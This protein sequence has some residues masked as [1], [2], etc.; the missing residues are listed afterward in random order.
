MRKR[1]EQGSDLGSDSEWVPGHESDD[2][3]DEVTAAVASMTVPSRLGADHAGPVVPTTGPP[4]ASTISASGSSNQLRHIASNASSFDP[5]PA[6]SSQHP[7]RAGTANS[8][9]ASSSRLV[10]DRHGWG[11]DRMHQQRR[12]ELQEDEDD[13]E[14]DDGE[15]EEDDEEEDDEAPAPDL[16]L[17]RQ[18][19]KFERLSA[20]SW[21]TVVSEYEDD[22]KN[23]AENG[24][25]INQVEEEPKKSGVDD[26][27][28]QLRGIPALQGRSV[29]DCVVELLKGTRAQKKKSFG[30]YGERWVWLGEDLLS[31]CYKSK[32]KE[33]HGRLNLTKVKKL[34]SS[35][36]ELVIEAADDRK[37]SL[38]LGTKD[39]AMIWLT[40]LSCLVPK[41]AKVTQSNP[42]LKERVNYDP[43]KDMWRG[44][45]LSTRKRV[46]EYI[47]L[48]GIGRGSFGKVKLALST[49]DKRF[50]AVKIITK[51][52]KGS[53]QGLIGSK[54]EQAMLRKL[55]HPNICRHRD[56]LYDDESD[57]FIIVVEYMARGVVM[58]SSKLEGVKPLSE[59]GV[60]EIMRDVVCGLEYLHFQNIVHRDLKPD[61]LLRAGDGTV[62]LSD[63]GE[64]RMYDLLTPEQRVKPSAP[65]TPAFIAPE[66]CMSD[67]GPK[68]PLESYAADIWSLGATMFYMVYGR[69]PFL[70]KSVFEIYDAICSQKLEFPD[71]PKISKKLRDLLKR[72]LT[73]EPS[74]RVTL[75]DVARHPW[76]VERVLQPRA[77]SKVNISSAEIKDAIRPATWT[78]PEERGER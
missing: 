61:N 13:D 23:H 42:I 76:F 49:S 66:L 33:E 15:E 38:T 26:A 14:P 73:K 5:D 24:W 6:F 65:G 32:R 57:R 67:K 45:L 19:A 63:F 52:K 8:D 3:L 72:M 18:D 78:I 27:S 10:S 37:L 53:T 69:A 20:D 29:L 74:R 55:I 48:G 44:K 71:Q 9:L 58:D 62:K 68:A 25:I 41:K 31:L 12:T 35:D 36:R 60:R 22:N 54:E 50:Y 39:E 21:V 46:N 75:E 4:G 1:T 2:G 70:A 34:K 11:A 47:L 40:G 64:A 77:L 56:I 30:R 16:S 43:L 7:S 17:L 28:I 51:G 59:D